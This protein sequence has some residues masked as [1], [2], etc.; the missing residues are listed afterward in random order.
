ML[1]QRQQRKRGWKLRRQLVIET[2]LEHG[3]ACVNTFH[4]RKNFTRALYVCMH[5]R[6]NVKVCCRNSVLQRTLNK[7]MGCAQHWLSC[8]LQRG[9]DVAVYCSGAAVCCSVWQCVAVC[10][11]VLQCVAT[12]LAQVMSCA[13]HWLS[14]VLQCDILVAVC[15]SVSQRVAVCCSVLQCV[16]V[17]C[18]VLQ[19]VAVCCS[20][21]WTRRC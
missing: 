10:C 5:L 2:L 13:Q 16:A 6:E 14:D 12:Y 20:I 18:S 11:S 21:P 7:Q 17:C 15:C 19:C 9:A 8:V 1:G 3:P 4:L